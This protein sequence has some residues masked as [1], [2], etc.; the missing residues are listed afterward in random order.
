V[1]RTG[2]TGGSIENEDDDDD[3]EGDEDEVERYI[4]EENEDISN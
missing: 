3:D 4:E 2:V 1:G